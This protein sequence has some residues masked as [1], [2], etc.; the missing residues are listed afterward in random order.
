MTK[1]YT[2]I[3]DA[4]AGKKILTFIIAYN[5][6]CAIGKV[7]D[8]IRKFA[9]YS[10]I[11][12]IDDCSTDETACIARNAGIPVVSH[13]INSRTAG[14]AAVRTAMI[15]AYFNNYDICCQFDGDGQ[16]D[17]AYLYRI[18]EPVA[19]GSADFVIGSRFMKEQGYVP[20][21]AR[22]TGIKIFSRITS[23]IIRQ[24]VYDISSGFK[25]SGKKIIRLFALYPHLI[26]DTNEMI[27]LAKNN[28]AQILEV[29][30][31]M[32]A[33]ETGNSWYSLT[34]FILYP[35]RSLL[36]ILAVIV[37]QRNV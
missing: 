12:V 21:F 11:V 1:Q 36:Y 13:M 18:I 15:Y 2:Y 29:P 4:I 31:K 37:R 10:D 28:G 6:E 32:R 35:L 34:K 14:Y 17:A 33:R 9:A 8:D 19:V 27:I 24:R 7:I 26:S 25:A 20:S 3:N 5:E 30:V 16:H 23:F 22:A